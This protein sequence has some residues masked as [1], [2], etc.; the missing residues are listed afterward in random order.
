MEHAGHLFKMPPRAPRA[1]GTNERGKLL[2]FFRNELNAERKGTKYP[3]ISKGR[4]S[5]ILAGL[6]VRDL[7]YMQSV[8][9]DNVRRNGT[10][11][12]IKHFWWSLRP[13]NK[14]EI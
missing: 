2:E 13:E 4:I 8:Y 11:S 1:S 6:E 12:A 14:P 7:R 9:K 3:P 5:V 10:K